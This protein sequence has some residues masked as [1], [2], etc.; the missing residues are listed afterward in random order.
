MI[1]LS[2]R[3]QLIFGSLSLATMYLVLV[4]LLRTY[5]DLTVDGEYSAAD[6]CDHFASVVPLDKPKLTLRRAH[7]DVSVDTQ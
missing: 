4:S 1:S 7:L 5:S 2:H 6:L 3:F